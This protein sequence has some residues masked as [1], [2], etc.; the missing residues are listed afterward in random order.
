[1]AMLNICDL[2][3]KVL[4]ACPDITE[5]TFPHLFANKRNA[6]RSGNVSKITQQEEFRKLMIFITRMYQ[7]WITITKI[8]NAGKL[9]AFT[10]DNY[11]GQEES[12]SVIEH[13]L[14]EMREKNVMSQKQTTPPWMLVSA[15]ANDLAFCKKHLKAIEEHIQLVD[16]N[17]NAL[18]KK[19]KTLENK[20]KRPPQVHL[21]ELVV[22]AIDDKKHKAK[23]QKRKEGKA[24]EAKAKRKRNTRN[25]V[26]LVFNCLGKTYVLNNSRIHSIAVNHISIE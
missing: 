21:D 25:E 23:K 26:G 2:F 15:I 9:T 14:A 4:I 24:K 22:R 19:I 1:M 3:C 18:A 17:Q 10:F 7:A 11:N 8:G 20:T 13:H 16:T 6:N 5:T 12:F